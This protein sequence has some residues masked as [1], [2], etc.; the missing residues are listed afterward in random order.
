MGPRRHRGWPRAEGPVASRGGH[1]GSSDAPA[2]SLDGADGRKLRP[3]GEIY[4][5]A[6]GMVCWFASCNRVILVSAS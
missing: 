2:R 4:I 1:G 6:T 3:K 5:S